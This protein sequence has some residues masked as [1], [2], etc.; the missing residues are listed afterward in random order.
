MVAN[1]VQTAVEMLEK[2]IEKYQGMTSKYRQAL[3]LA[4]RN[5][6]ELELALKILREKHGA[7]PAKVTQEE[8]PT[9]QT[10]DTTEPGF[11][12][13][14]ASAEQGG[15]QIQ[16]TKAIM[17]LFEKHNQLSTHQLRKLL[18][19]QGYPSNEKK[20][21]N[22]I[23]NLLGRQVGK[24]IERVEKGVYRNKKNYD[25]PKWPK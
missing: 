4:E 18:A 25:I 22:T 24:T 15:R 10:D 20:N 6:S 16:W 1:G 12:L 14:P 19:E 13:K 8:E 11:E 7:I 23:A 5:L 2:E 21:Q 17:A 9:V 3:E